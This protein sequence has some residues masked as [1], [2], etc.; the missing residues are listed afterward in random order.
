MKYLFL[1]S[2]FVI[3]HYS[4][5]N[6]NDTN[7]ITTTLPNITPIPM[8]SLNPR[9]KEFRRIDQN[10]DDKLTFAEYLLGDRNYLEQQSRNFHNLDMN[11]DGEVDRNEFNSYFKKQDETRKIQALQADNFFKQFNPPLLDNMDSQSQNMGNNVFGFP[12]QGMFNLNVPP[13]Q[14]D[15]LPSSSGKKVDNKTTQST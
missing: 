6:N 4:L 13:Q 8:E 9:L 3:C 7:E 11:G 14:N 2:L 10:K 1:L 5:G 15:P 12:G